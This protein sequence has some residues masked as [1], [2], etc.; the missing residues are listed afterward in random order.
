MANDLVPIQVASAIQE[1]VGIFAR[2]I[3]QAPVDGDLTFSEVLT[4]GR[5]ERFGSATA[6]DLARGVQV[7]PQAIGSTLVSLEGRGMVVRRADPSDGRRLLITMSKVGKRALQNRR[8]ALNEEM[9]RILG[10]RFTQAEMKTLVAA[11]PL[12]ERLGECL[13]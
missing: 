9:A 4:L 3:R 10:N 8:D 13:L 7:T 2:Q 12:I 6:S 1:S 5:L 11:L